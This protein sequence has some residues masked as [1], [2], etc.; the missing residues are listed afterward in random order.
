M[1]DHDSVFVTLED[2]IF[3]LLAS[4]GRCPSPVYV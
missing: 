4:S 3:K 1:T 2:A